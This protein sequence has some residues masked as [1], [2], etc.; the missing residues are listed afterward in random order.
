M[1]CRWK[2]AAINQ[3][4]FVANLHGFFISN[5]QYLEENHLYQGFYDF[6]KLL[7]Q[8]RNPQGTKRFLMLI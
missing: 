4:K 1:R 7:E 3:E 2:E 5:C 6:C 8:Q